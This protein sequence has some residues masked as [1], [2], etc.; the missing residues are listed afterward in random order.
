M[1]VNQGWDRFGPTRIL[2]STIKDRA[3]VRRGIDA[4]LQHDFDRVVV[5][6]GQVVDRGGRDGLRLG[7]AWLVVPS[8]E[9]AP[10]RT[11]R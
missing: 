9:S 6:H 8:G 4:V 1:R 5:G 3:A 2:R 7:F 11:P 10:T